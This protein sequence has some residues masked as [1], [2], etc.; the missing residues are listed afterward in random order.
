MEH[1]KIKNWENYQHYKNR[2]PP[3]IKLHVKI[4]NDRK[5]A[6]LSCA[7]KGLLMQLWVLGAE[8][9][10]KIPGSLTE[11]Q[12]RLRDKAIKAEHL[13]LLIEKGF[14]QN[15]KQ[16]LA[17]DNK[18]CSETETET[19]TETEKSNGLFDVFWSEYPNKVGKKKALEEWKKVK[20]IKELMPKILSSLKAQKASK[21][22]K[23]TN[24]K[25]APEFQDP[26]RWIKNERW[27]DEVEAL[28]ENDATADPRTICR[29]CKKVSEMIISGECK[30]C[31]AGVVAP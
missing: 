30:A 11:L 26:E 12:F 19:E 15:C 31:R 6:A 4:L 16:P 14:L 22:L 23:K 10:G 3:W 29:T 18:K 5:F 17:G 21:K 13:N 28:V 27:E 1:L 9:D 24:G 2:N 25:F 8:N 20:S 7:S